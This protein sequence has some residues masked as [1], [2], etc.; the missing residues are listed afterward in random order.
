M[1]ERVHLN[2]RMREI[3]RDWKMC[4]WLV[5]WMST[6]EGGRGGGGGMLGVVKE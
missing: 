2:A 4:C 1:I 5:A 6:D 3:V